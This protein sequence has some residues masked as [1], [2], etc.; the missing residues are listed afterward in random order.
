MAIDNITIEMTE[1]RTVLNFNL[2]GLK[3]VVS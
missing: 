2:K 1:Y 3:R